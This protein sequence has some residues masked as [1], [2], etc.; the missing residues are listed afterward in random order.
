MDLRT[1]DALNIQGY[2]Y[3]YFQTLIF[4]E[5]KAGNQNIAI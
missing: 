1:V 2:V 3:W 5:L 4:K